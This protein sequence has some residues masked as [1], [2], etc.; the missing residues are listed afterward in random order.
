[1]IFIGICDL[2]LKRGLFPQKTVTTDYTYPRTKVQ[3]QQNLIDTCTCIYMYVFCTSI[4]YHIHV[5]VHVSL[6]TVIWVTK[7][8]EYLI[9][10]LG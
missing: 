2:I 7:I 4:F 8:Q 9:R 5:H 6:V 10:N 3:L 1:M